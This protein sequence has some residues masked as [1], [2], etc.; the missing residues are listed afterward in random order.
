M[1]DPLVQAINI[2]DTVNNVKCHPSHVGTIR[3]YSRISTGIRVKV[4]DQKRIWYGVVLTKAP[5]EVE[6]VVAEL[7]RKSDK[8][9]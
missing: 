6:R 8:E 5:D 1:N 4:Y 2:G 9:L 3:P 7:N